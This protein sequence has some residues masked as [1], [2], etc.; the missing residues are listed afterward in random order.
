MID[1]LKDHKE[2]SDEAKLCLGWWKQFV[3]FLFWS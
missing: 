2:W 3:L 1:Y